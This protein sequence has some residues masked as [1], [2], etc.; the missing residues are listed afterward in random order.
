MLGL[1][2][3]A[4]CS[5]CHSADD[6]GGKQRDRDA[7]AHRFARRRD[8]SR[9]EALLGRAERCGHGG[10]PGAVRPERGPGEPGQ[11]AHRRPRVQVGR[12]DSRRSQPGLAIAEKAYA[13][14][15]RA[16][17]D[18]RFRKARARRV[19][20]D[21]RRADRGPRRE[22]PRRS[23]GAALG[24]WEERRRLMTESHRSSRSRDRRGFINWFL[25]RAPGPSCS[26]CSTRS[27]GT[28][29]PPEVGESTAA[30]VTLSIKP[31]DVKP[32]TGQIFKFGSRPGILIRTSGR[33]AP[34]LLRPSAPTST[35]PS[36]TGRI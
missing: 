14:G 1:G 28:S 12:R 6:K 21:H 31:E 18:L 3:K 7:G 23:T 13:R 20:G 17:E 5:T 33:G 2:D 16:L 15:V 32:N 29:C 4:V 36:S 10:E 22:D 9:A 11:G 19:A 8:T 34:G 24:A 26:R 27:A 30:T 25:G 35:A